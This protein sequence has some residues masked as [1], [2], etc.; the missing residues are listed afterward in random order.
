[1]PVSYENR[2]TKFKTFQIDI[3]IRHIEIVAA[4]NLDAYSKSREE[5]KTENVYAKLFLVHIQFG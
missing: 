1:M 4:K 2:A 3:D 5:K